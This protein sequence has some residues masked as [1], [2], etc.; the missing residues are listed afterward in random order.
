MR[1]VAVNHSFLLISGGKETQWPMVL[2]RALAPLGKLRIVTEAE[3]VP[4]AVQSDCDVVIID[5][6]TVYD[7]ALLTSRLRAERPEACVVVAT[8]SPTWQR[9]R[10][11]LQAGAMDYFRTSLD[12]EELRSRILRAIERALPL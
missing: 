2:Q 11:A 3:A 5:A 12:E 10:E 1:I 4:V 8:A 6:G 7:T 9:A